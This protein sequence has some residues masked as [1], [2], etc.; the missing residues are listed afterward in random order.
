MLNLRQILIFEFGM[1]FEI[2]KK[3]MSKIQNIMEQN[4]LSLIDFLSLSM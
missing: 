1:K 4:I 3:L 2:W